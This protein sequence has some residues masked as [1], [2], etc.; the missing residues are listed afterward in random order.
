[1]LFISNDERD[2]SGF[3][4]VGY[5]SSL[6]YEVMRPLLHIFPVVLYMLCAICT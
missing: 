5:S 3:D 2:E 6:L 4:S 1:M